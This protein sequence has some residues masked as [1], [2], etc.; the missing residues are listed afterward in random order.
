MARNLLLK[1][2]NIAITGAS[3]GIGKETARLLKELGANLVL[4]SRSSK[5]IVSENVLEMFLDVTNE[6][7]VKGFC[8]RAINHFGTIDI[9]INS[10]GVG[11]FSSVIDSSVQDFDQMMNVNL[12]GT[13]LTC[14]HFGKHM[15]EESNGH[16]L[17]LVS[18]VGTTALSGCGGYSASKFGVL[19]LTRVLQVELR[20]KGVQV[21]AVLPGAVNSEFWEH[22]EPKPDTSNMI[23]VETV[24]NHIIYIINQPAGAYIDEITIM[25]PR[26]IL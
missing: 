21:T 13:Y 2:K 24:A 12:R 4:G 3:K 15:V 14:K 10:A 25:P 17:N 11:T 26:G 9:L 19:G 22:I 23:P 5:E 1:G 8:E 18:I 20:Q 6:E 7:S 16:I